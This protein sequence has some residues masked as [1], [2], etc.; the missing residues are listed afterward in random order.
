MGQIEEAKMDSGEDE[1][2][3][4]KPREWG[5]DGGEEMGRVEEWTWKS[6]VFSRTER[7]AETERRRTGAERDE[8]VFAARMNNSMAETRESAE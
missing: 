3:Y 2:E 6:V 4:V 7:A 5:R 1:K 8:R